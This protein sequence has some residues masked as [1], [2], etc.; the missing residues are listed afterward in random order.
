MHS[1][2]YS[3]LKVRLNILKKL[4]NRLP[5]N[6]ALWL[7]HNLNKERSPRTFMTHLVYCI[8]QYSYFKKTSVLKSSW[9]TEVDLG[10]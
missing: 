9:L 10:G 1:K 3:E 4:L 6:L 7:N 5:F 2:C 8:L